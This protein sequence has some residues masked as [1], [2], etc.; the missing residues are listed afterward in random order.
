MSGLIRKQELEYDVIA[1]R[2]LVDRT[3]ADINKTEQE[4]RYREEYI[5]HL[6]KSLDKYTDAER[7]SED[8]LNAY[9]EESK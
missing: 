5:A 2:Q 6:E 4:I 7:L 1:A 8:R 9:E 3:I